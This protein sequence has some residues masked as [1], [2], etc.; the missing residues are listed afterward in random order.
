[1]SWGT[2][3]VNGDGKSGDGAKGGSEK[4]SAPE[5]SS[6]P[7]LLSSSSSSWRASAIANTVPTTAAKSIRICGEEGPQ[8]R[9]R[10]LRRELRALAPN[11]DR[12][13]PRW[14]ALAAAALAG[15]AS[16]HVTMRIALFASTL[17]AA[18]V[19]LNVLRGA[20]APTATTAATASRP[21][22]LAA[23]APARSPF[24]F[25]QQLDTTEGT[26]IFDEFM[27]V[28]PETGISKPSARHADPPRNSAAQFRR[29][30]HA[31]PPLRSRARGEGKAVP[32]LPRRVLQRGREA[33]A[34]RG[35]LPEAQARPRVLDEPRD[36]A[37]EL[38]TPPARLAPGAQPLP[39]SH[40]RS[41]SRRTRSS[42]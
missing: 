21:A 12:S 22:L 4:P 36:G 2:A 23:D 17:H 28:D 7:E 19:G 38:D 33:A 26:D 29:V 34:Q 35:R 11:P 3:T 39:P 20:P 40:S 31:R 41:S 5:P 30:A 15:D 1:M 9:R 13:L 6:A 14:R 25:M 18:V 10:D 24:A 16:H 37:P 27:A 42:S 32:G 8:L